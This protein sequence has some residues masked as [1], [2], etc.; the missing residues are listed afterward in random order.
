MHISS[1]KFF[2]YISTLRPRTGYRPLE[3]SR[4]NEDVLSSDL[5]TNCA[6]PQGWFM[7]VY[8]SRLLRQRNLSYQVAIH[9]KKRLK[10]LVFTYISPLKFSQQ[11]CGMMVPF[12][13][14]NWENKPTSGGG[15]I[16][17]WDRNL[18]HPRFLLILG[19]SSS[20]LPSPAQLIWIWSTKLMCSRHISENWLWWKGMFHQPLS[21]K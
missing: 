14:E 2:R 20:N 21:V 12:G 7:M 5:A 6:T 3:E 11:H 1:L 8:A 19:K 13:I 17:C 9:Q 4:G 18:E 16:S 15:R 10:K